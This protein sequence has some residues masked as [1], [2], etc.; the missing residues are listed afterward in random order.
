MIATEYA[1]VVKELWSGKKRN[2]APIKLRVRIVFLS[3]LHLFKWKVE[4]LLPLKQLLIYLPKLSL[5]F[6]VFF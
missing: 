2:I 4:G 6:I 1:N 5:A 3:P